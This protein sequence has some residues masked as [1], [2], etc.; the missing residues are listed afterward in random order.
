MFAPVMISCEERG[1][2]TERPYCIMEKQ[3]FEKSVRIHV[4]NEPR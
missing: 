4:A 1:E 3:E 2:L